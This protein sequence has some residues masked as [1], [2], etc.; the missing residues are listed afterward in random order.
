M[1]GEGFSAPCLRST[2]CLCPVSQEHIVSPARP[3]CSLPFP[4]TW[5]S[6]RR[7][8]P[9]L[10]GTECLECDAKPKAPS[11]MRWL[12]AWSTAPSA[13]SSLG[14]LSAIYPARCGGCVPSPERFP[15][16]PWASLP[17]GPSPISALLS[18][19]LSSRV[20]PIICGLKA[21]TREGAG[22]LWFPPHPR[23]LDTHTVPGA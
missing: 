10:T 13:A 21:R 22:L 19:V 2:L 11:R 12:I 15:G 20:D 17:L 6:N 5:V 3:L 16:R 1:G 4:I 18:P 9:A 14:S 8:S 23:D 7:T